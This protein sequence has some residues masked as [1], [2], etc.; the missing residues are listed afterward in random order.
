MPVLACT[1]LL[2]WVLQRTRLLMNSLLCCMQ[3]ALSTGAMIPNSNSM[4][5][6]PME[7]CCSPALLLALNHIN[8]LQQP[9]TQW[10]VFLWV[11]NC[12]HQQLI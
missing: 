10:Y 4:I 8:G 7:P 5:E 3:L 6:N 9:I 1:L 11:V 2:F 12:P